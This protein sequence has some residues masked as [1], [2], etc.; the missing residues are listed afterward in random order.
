MTLDPARAKAFARRELGLI[1]DR[2]QLV[3]L[4]QFSDADL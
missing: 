4:P 3:D 1:L 2:Q